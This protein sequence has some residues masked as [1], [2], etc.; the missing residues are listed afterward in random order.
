MDLSDIPHEVVID[1]EHRNVLIDGQPFP[2]LLTDRLPEVDMDARSIGVVW[3][4]LIADK[5]TYL[6]GVRMDASPCPSPAISA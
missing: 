1:M 3:L 5:V 2:Y 6:P 4:P